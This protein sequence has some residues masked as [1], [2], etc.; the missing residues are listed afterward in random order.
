MNR[1]LRPRKN[2]RACRPVNAARSCGLTGGECRA[3]MVRYVLAAGTIQEPTD[4]SLAR[5]FPSFCVALVV[6]QAL[7][8]QVA[9][10]KP[11]DPELHAVCYV[12][13]PGPKPKAD[14]ARA[15]VRVARPGKRVT[16]VLASDEPVTWTITVTD[17][18]F[19]GQSRAIRSVSGSV[20]RLSSRR[21]STTGSLFHHCSERSRGASP[22]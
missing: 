1:D 10:P 17:S 2:S 20:G 4:M 16:L 5:L 8:A 14:E 7:A 22:R 15:A 19:G 13:E 21:E 12:R 6:V 11:D 18:S 9:D 3:T